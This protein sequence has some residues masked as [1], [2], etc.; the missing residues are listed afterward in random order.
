MLG[1]M[2]KILRVNLTDKRITEEE[3][4]EGVARQFLGGRG[5]GAKIL[6]DELKP[7]I[8]PLGPENKLV[9]AAGVVTGIPFGGNCRYVIMAKSPLTGI[10]GEANASGFFGPELRFAGFDA[11]VVEG[12]SEKPVYLWIH[13]GEAEIRDASHLWGKITGDTEGLIREELQDSKVRIASIGPGGENLVRFACVLSDIHHA[14]GRSGMGAVMGSKKLKAIA[15]RGTQKIPLADSGRVLEL[16]KRANKEVWEGAY[17]D[18]LHKY[19][20]DGDLDDLHATGRLPTK[21]FRR[22]TFEGYENLTGETMAETILVRRDPCFAC[23]V[24]CNQ[25]VAAKEPYVVDPAYGGPEYE[26]AAALGSLCMNDNLVVLAKANELCNK[27]SIDTI[28]TGVSIAFAMECYEKGLITKEDT[29]GL[30]LTWGSDEAIIQLIEKIARREGIGDLLAE[31][32]KRAA[33]KIG[34]GAGEFAMHIKG[35]EV[36]MHE[37]RGKKGVGLAYAISNR[38]ACH[39]Q[40]EHDD[41]FE[42]E[43]WLFPEI[44]LDQTVH[45]LDMGKDKARMVKV[46]GDFKALYDSLSVCMYASWPEGGVKPHTIRDIVAAATGWDVTMTELMLVGERAFNLCRAFNVREGI[47]RKDDVLPARLM[48]PLPEGLYSGEAIPQDAFDKMLDYY[49]EF[50]GWDKGTGIPT[51]ERL[52]NLGLGYVAE[53]LGALG[54]LK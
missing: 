45:R 35:Q 24:S 1:Y 46:L 15:V 21:N 22:C 19:G 18:L 17:G 43:A 27:Y 34:R 48:E 14:N 38:G 49:Y 11:L 30:D 25:V 40:A 9:V 39:L 53:E 28:S 8:D 31:G 33:E 10:W 20:S 50:R 32:V 23:P 16:A 29:G 4:E 54:L 42:D 13:D 36:P 6:F 41:F 12:K 37:P 52:E 5:L 47:S 3:L 51:R 26:T 2:G 7:G 44:G